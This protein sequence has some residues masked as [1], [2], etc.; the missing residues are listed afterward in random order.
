MPTRPGTQ[1]LADERNAGRSGPRAGPA[2]PPPSVA[3]RAGTPP[4][5]QRPPRSPRP[6]AIPV[7]V[8]VPAWR[9]RRS[10]AECP[11]PAPPR[12]PA[13]PSGRQLPNA[14]QSRRGRTPSRWG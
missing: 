1:V 9:C 8:P 11:P 4:P 14:P 5:P 3:R 6:P 12:P 7:S 2:R 13:M 10:R